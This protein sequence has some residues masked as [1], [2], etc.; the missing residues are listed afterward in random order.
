[1]FLFMFKIYILIISHFMQHRILINFDITRI[2]DVGKCTHKH[3]ILHT[4]KVHLTPS[5]SNLSLFIPIKIE[6]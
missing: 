6:K 5:N 4:C 1:M 2:C 3:D